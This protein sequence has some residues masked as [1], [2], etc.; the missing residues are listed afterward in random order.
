MLFLLVLLGL[1]MTCIIAAAKGAWLLAVVAGAGPLAFGLWTW[2]RVRR[3]ERAMAGPQCI[4][5][6]PSW[7]QE[8]V[9]EEPDGLAFKTPRREGDEVWSFSAP[10][11]MWEQLAGYGGYALLR[12][13]V[14]IETSVTILN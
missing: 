1:V 6:P 7:L 4:P 2:A 11:E 13:G 8:K 10:K 12:E 14:V 3:E 5:I 9:A